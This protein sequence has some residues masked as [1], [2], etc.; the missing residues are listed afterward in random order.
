ME[1]LTPISSLTGGI[2]IGLAVSVLLLFNGRIGGVSGILGSLLSPA[3]GDIGWR[4]AFLVGM[5]GTGALASRVFPEFFVSGIGRSMPALI[6]AGFLV[7]FGTRLGNGCTSG[8]GVCGLSR[9][10]PRSL[11]ATVTFM[12]SGAATVFIVVH[13]IGGV[14]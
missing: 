6:A 12:I 2:L 14:V 11:L 8:H 9:F 7:G 3:A 1:Q 13:L 10:S 4:V 5:L